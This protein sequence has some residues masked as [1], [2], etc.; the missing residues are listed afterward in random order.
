MIL[1]CPAYNTCIIC[2][3][4]CHFIDSLE[5]DE[6]NVQERKQINETKRIHLHV[7]HQCLG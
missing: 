1:V 5:I 4:R 6:S 7:L 2:I 3:F